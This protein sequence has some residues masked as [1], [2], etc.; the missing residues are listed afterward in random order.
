MDSSVCDL[1]EERTVVTSVNTI[2]DLKGDKGPSTAVLW[3]L[4]PVVLS[5]GIKVVAH[6]A[7][8]FDASVHDGV[9]ALVA[10]V[11]I[12]FGGTA[13][14]VGL[15]FFLEVLMITRARRAAGH[16]DLFPMNLS[17]NSYQ[18]AFH[19]SGKVA[20]LPKKHQGV[21][22]ALRPYAIELYA[23]FRRYDGPL[24]R[25]RYSEIISLRRET[26]QLF[27]GKEPG[28]VIETVNGPFELGFVRA[29]VFR[30]FSISKKQAEMRFKLFESALAK[31]RQITA[32]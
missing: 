2:P 10:I 20:F 7:Q 29:V 15:A 30:P 1:V 8:E 25:I 5:S 17:V 21:F 16:R 23:G 3:L 11:V 22:V 19:I 4:V 27:G 24:L 6:V 13:I 28:L 31:G 9:M 14:L 18:Q 12:F 26:L 32:E